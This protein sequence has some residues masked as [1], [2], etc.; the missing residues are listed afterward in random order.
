MQKATSDKK[1][2]AAFTDMADEAVKDQN[3]KKRGWGFNSTT[4]QT[5]RDRQA[6]AINKEPLP[7]YLII[8]SH[9][10]PKW[11]NGWMV[12]RIMPSVEEAGR[13]LQSSL[14]QGYSMSQTIPGQRLHA[15]MEHGYDML[16]A[17]MGARTGGNEQIQNMVDTRT[18]THTLIDG[19]HG[20]AA[21]R[22]RILRKSSCDRQTEEDGLK[23]WRTQLWME[24]HGQLNSSKHVWDPAIQNLRLERS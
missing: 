5:V 14:A 20:R 1:W 3:K 19:G 23:H 7:G 24:W 9:Q 4:G 8:G 17:L 10:W 21:A 15:V 12:V 13:V 18:R 11:M 6:G 22:C 2:E 16:E